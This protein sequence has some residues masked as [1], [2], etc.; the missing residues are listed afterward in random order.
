M[1][2][3][4]E[5]AGGY[6]EIAYVNFDQNAGDAGNFNSSAADELAV[7]DNSSRVSQV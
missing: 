7:A 1:N 6:F 2:P 5:V 3:S 4:A